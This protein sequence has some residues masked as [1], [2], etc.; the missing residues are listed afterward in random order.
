MVRRERKKHAVQSRCVSVGLV[1]DK[2]MQVSHC[3]HRFNASNLLLCLNLLLYDNAGMCPLPS[4]PLA[5]RCAKRQN[6]NE[7]ET[8]TQKAGTLAGRNKEETSMEAEEK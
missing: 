7:G 8:S 2:A 6:A 5:S 3:V 1:A 4:S